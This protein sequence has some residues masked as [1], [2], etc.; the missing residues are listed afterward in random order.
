[1]KTSCRTEHYQVPVRSTVIIVLGT[2]HEA[3]NL[4]EFVSGSPVAME[5]GCV[6]LFTYICAVV[7]VLEAFRGTSCG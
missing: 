4:L 7:V 5:L 1:M 3:S 6:S 2:N